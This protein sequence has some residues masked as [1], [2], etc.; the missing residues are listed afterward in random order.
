QP[1]LKR[2][3]ECD[4]SS[5]QLIVLCVASIHRTDKAT[6]AEVTDGW[7][8][9]HATLDSVLAE[10]ASRDRL[11]V[12]D[13]IACVGLRMGGLADG[14]SPLT[15]MANC[16]TLLLNANCVQRAPWDAKL[17]FQ[18]RKAMYLSL[19]A[20]LELGGPIGA[21]LDVVVMRCYPMLYMETLPG[22][23]RVVRTER[24]E[25][26]ISGTMAEKRATMVQDLKERRLM[27]HPEH[28]RACL[29]APNLRACQEGKELYDYVMHHS[30]DPA[31][32][33]QQLSGAQAATL[34]RYAA[35]RQTEIET[36]IAEAVARDAPLR[37]VRAF[38]RL[39]VCDYPAHRYKHSEPKTDRLALVTVWGPR[40]LVP[41]DFAEG[42]RFLFTGLTVSPRRA[43]TQ[44][45]SQPEEACLRLNFN[46]T[47][48]HSK[49][50]PADPAVV[51]RSEFR[52]RGTLCID[53]L[54][55][56]KAGEEVDLAGCVA[57]CRA[58]QPGQSSVL[59][60]STNDEHGK[61]YSATVEFPVV[62]F[63]AI[64]VASG[65]QV[66]V[67]NCL[68]ASCTGAAQNSFHLRASDGTELVI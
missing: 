42:S 62:T 50:L 15:D 5:Q 65:C 38:F 55:H 2:I 14:V 43:R 4:S 22:G 12:G 30:S 19:S 53:E 6:L 52:E 1:A 17:G 33:Q 23:Q 29:G 44:T 64:S 11:R 48:S 46:S 28:T 41:A 61:S 56:V 54:C 32:V 59:H 40:A 66:T 26:R 9:V 25:Q 27:A 58:G 57:E 20:V 68:Y 45:H 35:E 21:A 24:E 34:D 3:L 63:G 13:K 49:A 31:V 18:H 37:Q 67:R 7:Y 51:Q 39:L 16:A 36:D 60:L 47:G 10:A 8:S